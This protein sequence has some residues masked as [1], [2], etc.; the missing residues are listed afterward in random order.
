MPHECTRCETVYPNGTEAILSGC[1]ECGW[2]R[3][4]YVKD[5][6]PE[7]EATPAQGDGEGEDRLKRREVLDR[8]E[9]AHEASGP[10]QAASVDDI[11]S[12]QM[13]EE[14]SYR[15]NVSSLMEKEEVIMSIGESGR[16]VVHL[17]SAFD[18]KGKKER[19]EAS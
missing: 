5:E 18:K 8:I 10:E 1:P 14:G 9:R 4:K 16:Y 15:I 6:E 2:N 7:E 19:N 12:V 3:F 13:E 17:G 11:A